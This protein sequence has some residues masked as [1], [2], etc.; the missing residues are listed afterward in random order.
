MIRE[1]GQGNVE[2]RVTS[3]LTIVIP[4]LDAGEGLAATLDAVAEANPAGLR[5]ELVVVDG[6]SR[7]GTVR[8]ATACG[9]RPVRAPHQPMPAFPLLLRVSQFICRVLI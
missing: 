6:D 3:P 5:L 2:Q 7:D 4:T 8:C 1:G 9:A